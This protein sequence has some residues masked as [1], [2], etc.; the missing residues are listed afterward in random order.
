MSNNSSSLGGGFSD[1]SPSIKLCT[2]KLNDSNFSTWRYNMCNALGYMNLD[3]YIKTHTAE[4]KARPEYTSKLKQVTTFICLHLGREDST[5]FVD[6]LDTYDP[7]ALWDSIITYYA[8][9]SVKKAANVME[10]LHNI[11]FVE[12]EMQKS[13]NLFHQTFHLMLEVSNKQ[14]DKKTLEAV[15]VFLVMKRLPPSFSVFRTL[16]FASF[17]DPNTQILMSS[18]LTDLELELRHQIESQDLL[19]ASSSALEV[20]HLSRPAASTPGTSTS[21]QKKP[22]RRA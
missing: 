21:H 22:P 9:K 17:K 20:T 10:K 2:E 4:L 7:K 19:P 5:R 14:F 3:E 13:I 11:T 8:A 12:G 6:D 16:K 15:W 18:F 1:S